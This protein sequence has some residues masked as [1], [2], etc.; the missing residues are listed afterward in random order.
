MGECK[1]QRQSSRIA[2]SILA[3]TL[4]Q[5]HAPG[6]TAGDLSFPRVFP[7]TFATNRLLLSLTQICQILTCRHPSVLA[8]KDWITACVP[9]LDEFPVAPAMLSI[10]FNT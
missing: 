10:V 9:T 8:V 5:Q 7:E 3:M 6:V 4:S 2:E 1:L